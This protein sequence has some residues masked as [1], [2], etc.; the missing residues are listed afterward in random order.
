MI[1]LT[2]DNGIPPHIL[3]IMAVLAGFTVANLYYNQPLVVGM[4]RLTPL[5]VDLA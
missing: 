2:P 4:V 3:L 5:N 1:R